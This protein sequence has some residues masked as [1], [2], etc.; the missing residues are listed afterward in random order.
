[1]ILLWIILHLFHQGYGMISVTTAQIGESVTF[2]CNFSDS[3]YSNTRVKWYKQ[4]SGHGLIL[5]TTLMKTTTVSTFEKPFSPSRF[6][7]NYTSTRSSLTIL[8]TA[9]DDEAVYYCSVITWSKDE[10]SGTYLS[11]KEN[12]RRTSG[13]T[14][15]QRP[16]KSGQLHPRGSVSLQCSVLSETKT[17]PGDQSIHWFRAKSDSSPPNIIY[18]SGNVPHGCDKRPDEGSPPRNCHYHFNAYDAG[19]YYCALATC[20]EIIFGNGTKLDIEETTIS[21]CNDTLMFNPVCLLS[22]IILAISLTVIAFL[23]YA[24]KDQTSSQQKNTAIRNIKRDDTWVY[25]AVVFT[26]ITDRDVMKN[27]KAAERQR[28]YAAVKAFGLD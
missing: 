24:I 17:C 19:T 3:E 26:T 5:I 13:Y 10:W 18:S 21:F 14:V 16:L 15:T 20:G 12:T 11:I 6:Q 23:I 27:G 9:E 25:S 7:A 4:P 1:M 8:K 2:S 22:V 28:I